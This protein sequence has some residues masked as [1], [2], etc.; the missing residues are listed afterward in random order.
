MDVKKF[1]F[2]TTVG[3]LPWCFA[4]AYIGFLFGPHWADLESLFVYFD[5]VVIAGIIG[6][7]AY[8][9]YHRKRIIKGVR[10]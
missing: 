5:I 8:A 2:Y 7:I 6:F 3:S 1:S 4:L 9:V 10:G